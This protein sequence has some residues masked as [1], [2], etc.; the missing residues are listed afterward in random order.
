M[1]TR[2]KNTHYFLLL[3]HQEDV[4]DERAK[5]NAEKRRP[6]DLFRLRKS[7]LDDFLFSFAFSIIRIVQ[8]VALQVDSVPP[9]L[10]NG[11]GSTFRLFKLF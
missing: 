4:Q 10:R 1:T 3:L 7:A 8:Q 5:G 2:T 6:V 9:E 11:G